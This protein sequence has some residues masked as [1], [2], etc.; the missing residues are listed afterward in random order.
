MKAKDIKK[1]ILIVPLPFFP[2]WFTTPCCSW[3]RWVHLTD[4]SRHVGTVDRNN[5]LCREALGDFSSGGL[6]PS[7]LGA[8]KGNHKAFHS[9]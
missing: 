7:P 3:Q 1:G 2:P 6:S 8:E 5:M 4:A 9:P